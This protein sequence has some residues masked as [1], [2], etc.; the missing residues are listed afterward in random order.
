MYLGILLIIHK[1]TVQVLFTGAYIPLHVGKGNQQHSQEIL[2]TKDKRAQT[3]LQTFMRVS[4]GMTKKRG[5]QLESLVQG[6][7]LFPFIGF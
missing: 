3:E 6:Q 2:T 7:N 4:E 1:K 5:I